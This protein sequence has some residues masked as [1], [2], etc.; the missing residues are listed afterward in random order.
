M[1]SHLTQGNE[2]FKLLISFLFGR[3]NALSLVLYTFIFKIA[4]KIQ[5]L[6]ISE[7]ICN[8]YLSQIAPEMYVYIVNVSGRLFDIFKS[9]LTLY[10][11]E[12][13]KDVQKVR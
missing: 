6:Y 8:I 12:W 13:G 10:N 7:A 3:Q 1:G 9:S 2:Q 4:R 5:Y 11:K